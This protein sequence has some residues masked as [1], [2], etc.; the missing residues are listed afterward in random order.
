MG[1]LGVLNEIIHAVYLV[2]CLVP[3]EDPQMTGVR[4][5]VTGHEKGQ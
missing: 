3:I 5:N 4:M 2:M 1:S